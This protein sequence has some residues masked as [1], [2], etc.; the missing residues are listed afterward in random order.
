MTSVDSRS[1]LRFHY[2][3]LISAFVGIALS[4]YLLAQ[5]TRLKSGIQGGSSFCSFGKHVDCDVV[6]ASS[7]SEVLGIPLAGVGALY[8]FVLLLLVLIT[9]RR[10]SSDSAAAQMWL[11]RLT[12][13][14]LG[15]DLVLLGIQIALIQSICILCS[16]TYL[17]NAGLLIG[18]LGRKGGKWLRALSTL[19]ARDPAGE[20]LL[21]HPPLP[22]ILGIALVVYTAAVALIPSAIRLTSKNYSLVNDAIEQFFAS[23]PEK[24]VRVIDYKAGDGARG[25]PNSA[26]RV[27]EFSDFE[28]PFCRSAAFTLHTALEPFTDKIF[29]VFK[30]F[31][32]D[33]ACNPSV[34][35]QV[36]ANACP[37]A[38][39]A[40]CANKKGKFWDFHDLVF[41]KLP[42]ESVT[43]GVSALI[44]Q[45]STILTKDE[46]HGCLA[47]PASQDNV[48]LD[49][50]LGRTLEIKGTPSV[51]INGKAVTIPLTVENIRRL[52]QIELSLR[53]K[54]SP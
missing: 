5:H 38:R 21:P 40:Y 47:D 49:G 29:F 30:Q 35:Y 3:Q 15:A 39:L 16:I 42:Q 9:P 45:L 14:G 10:G 50:K 52:L 22:A 8:Y 13:L 43:A 7:Y 37:L 26:V 1:K 19:L 17:A 36:H 28:C 53:Q 41:I 32:L 24:K 46:A 54:T 23:W 12:L 34:Q 27:V 51:F 44:P 11:T 33:P 25:N 18:A 48:S 31:P 2:L 4:L 20:P 6:N